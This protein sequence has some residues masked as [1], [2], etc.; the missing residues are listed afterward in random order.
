MAGRL[1]ALF[2]LPVFVA[3]VDNSSQH[4]HQHQLLQQH[5]T[6]G[7]NFLSVRFNFE[8]FFIFIVDAYWGFYLLF[9]IF[10]FFCHQRFLNVI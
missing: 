4:Q 2:F 5:P 7:E 8:R 1:L 6:E 10:L 9:F 3:I